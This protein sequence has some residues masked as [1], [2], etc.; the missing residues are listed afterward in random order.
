MERFNRTL[1]DASHYGDPWNVGEQ[2]RTREL[3]K[4][5]QRGEMPYSHWSST[6]FLCSKF[7][8]CRM[9]LKVPYVS[10]CYTDFYKQICCVKMMLNGGI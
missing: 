6:P 10:V 7:E 2:C 4:T 1:R 5:L 9:I 8:D 3:H